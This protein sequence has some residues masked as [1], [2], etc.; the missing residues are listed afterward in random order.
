[1]QP[2]RARKQL[3]EASDRAESHHRR[4]GIFAVNAA[5]HLIER[6]WHATILDNLSRGGT[7]RNLKWLITEH[8]ARITS[9]KRSEECRRLDEHVKNRTRSN[10]AAQVAV[11]TSLIDP[12]TDF[13]INARG[14]LN[15][16]SRP[17]H[18]PEAPLVFA[19]TTGVRKAR[20]QER[21]CKETQALDFHS[22]YGAARE[23]RTST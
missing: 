22:P 13:D 15:C 4:C 5:A 1:M 9:S 6:G 20:P 16:S 11:T 17:Q 10:L 18:N 19:S 3:R 8:P 7:D 14:T 21:S 23:P 12:E 2:S